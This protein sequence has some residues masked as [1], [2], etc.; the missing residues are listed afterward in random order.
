MTDKQT[1]ELTGYPSVDKPWLK[2]FDKELLE[3]PIPKC[4]IYQSIYQNNKDYP[5]DFAINFFGNKISYEKMF[6]YVDICTKSL[7]KIGIKRGDCVTLCAAGIPEAIY[8]VLACSRIGAIANF[9]NPLFPKEQM[10]D[11]INETG[12]GWIFVLDEM[13]QYIE[14][15]LKD[16]CVKNVVI[17]PVTNSIS[18]L[19][20]KLLFVKSKA[21][22][23]LKKKHDKKF[24]LYNE[25][26][27][28]GRD[29]IGEMDSPYEEDTPAVMVYSSGTT[30]ASKGILLTNDGI[31]AIIQN[32][33]RDTFYGKRTETFLSMI[34]VW[35]STG[36]VLSIIMPLAHGVCVILEPLFSKES[37]ARDLTKYKPSL[38]LTATSLWLY[39]ATA[40][41]TKKIDLSN[42]TYPST[43][44]EKISEKDEHM[45]NAFFRD[46]G[47]KVSLLKGYGMCELGSE[48]T[49]TTAAK[50]YQSKVCSTGYPIL[51]A[52]VSA[53]NIDTD[54]ELKYGEHGEIRVCSPAR[55]KGYYKNPAATEGFFKTDKNGLVWGCTGDI[56]YVDEDGEVFILG[57]A[58]DSFQRENGET[59]YL[60]D[61]EDQIL[62][63]EDVDQCKVVDIN[64][65]GVTKLAAHIVFRKD[66]NNQDDCIGR[67]INRLSNTI[68]DYMCPDYYKKH[69]SM[70]VHPN[71]K[72]DIESLR[73]VRDGLRPIDEFFKSKRGY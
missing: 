56:G 41:E 65:D 52:I 1:D 47:C 9:I 26:A 67:I 20:A 58:S 69:L 48:V 22:K 44:G 72:R 29:Y 21:R 13:Y 54:E 38:T 27:A 25:F 53:F 39:V 4:T 57:R 62:K 36:I 18:P 61:I 17:I 16:T 3:E 19:L 45:L 46:H 8:I 14:A 51:N 70:P 55:M 7:R 42:M 11:R 40:E 28:I 59:V 60:F 10:V 43:G 5:Q 66:A 31:N 12:A 34:P 6:P 33:K 30:G 24:Y 37:F 63:E 32:Y 2:Y 35:F 68:P 15:A 50:G 23:I 49:G 73:S 71:G 64:V